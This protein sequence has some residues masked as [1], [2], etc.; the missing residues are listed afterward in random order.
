MV[1]PRGTVS[2]VTGRVREGVRYHRDEGHE[3]QGQ[4]LSLW[5]IG[6]CVVNLTS[7]SLP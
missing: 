2:L 1:E 6:I 5:S 3:L 4:E 7:E